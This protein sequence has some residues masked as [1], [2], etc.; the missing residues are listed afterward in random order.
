MSDERNTESRAAES[1]PAK[2][3][4]DPGRSFDRV[5]QERALRHAAR[6]ES[7]IE[8]LQRIAKQAKGK[9]ASRD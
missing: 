2:R 6:S 3:R 7:W 9:P 4:P 5:R 8:Q 1:Q